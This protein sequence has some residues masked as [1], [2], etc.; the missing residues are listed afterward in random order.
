MNVNAASRI[1][2]AISL[3]VFWRRAPSTS[4]IILSRK[5]APLSAVTRITMR[6]LS[7]RVPPVTALRSPPLSR[8]TG[9]DSPVIAASSTLAIPSTTSPSAGI[10]SPASHSTRSPFCSPGA[11][12]CCSRPFHRRRAIVS[13][14]ARRRLAACAFPR[15]SATASAKL[16][17]RTVNQSQIA[18]CVTNPRRLDSAV[19]IPTVVRAAR[20]WSRT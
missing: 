8:I 10:T 2:S 12:T 17:N 3:G 1:V 4:A 7:T 13:F 11:G 6:S 18:S 16:A 19:K 14:R 20:P 15:P 5:P 9:A